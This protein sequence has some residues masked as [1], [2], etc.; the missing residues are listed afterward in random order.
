MSESDSK[1]NVVSTSSAAVSTDVAIIIAIVIAVTFPLVILGF[2][3]CKKVWISG[4]GASLDENSNQLR[5]FLIS[6]AS[7]ILK[8]LCL[9][10]FGRIT[11]QA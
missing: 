7:Q 6:I 3:Y 11:I 1:V 4:K 8:M 5:Y 2:C 9:Q 10:Y